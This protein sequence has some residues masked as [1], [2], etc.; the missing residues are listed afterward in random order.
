MRRSREIYKTGIIHGAFFILLATLIVSGALRAHA[1]QLDEI[2]LTLKWKHQFQFAGYYAAQIKGFYR[3][4][5]L[6]V[7][8]EEARPGALPIDSV[9]GGRSQFGVAGPELLN[10]RVHG[11]PVVALAPIFQHSPTIIISRK[12]SHITTP[13]DLIGRTLMLSTSNP[14]AEVRSILFALAI[15]LNKIKVVPHSWNLEAL[16]NGDVDAMTAYSTDAP[17]ILRRRNMTPEIIRPQDY[18]VDFYGD[19]L[20][21]S[22]DFATRAPEEVEAFRRASIQG[23]DYALKHQDEIIR[24]I[25]TL[26][27]VVERGFD[28]A[29]LRFEAN[30][31]RQLIDPIKVGIGHQNPL[32]WRAMANQYVD[33]G[34][35][36][37]NY[38]LDGFFFKG[39]STVS[40]TYLFWAVGILGGLGVLLILSYVWAFQLRRAVSE[41]TASLAQ[42]EERFRAIFDGASSAIVTTDLGGRLTRWNDA[43]RTMLNDDGEFSQQ[44]HQDLVHPDDLE[45]VQNIFDAI[46]SGQVPTQRT[47]IRY[48]RK[49]GG[50]CW[51]EVRL[52]ALRAEN[53]AIIGS[54]AAINDITQRKQSEERIRVMGGALFNSPNMVIVTDTA[55]S[56]EY[57]NPMFTTL[58]GYDAKEVIGKNPRFLQSGETSSEVYAAMWRTIKAG[59]IWQGELKDRRK[60]G[61]Y[62]WSSVSFFPIAGN[63]GQISHFVAMHQDISARKRAQKRVVEAREQAEIANRA[64]SELL[65]N[66]SHE[67][68]TPLNAIIGFSQMIREQVFGEIGHPKYLEYVADIQTSG[69]HLLDLI[70]DILDVSAIEAGRLT[71]Q[72]HPCDMEKII[73][74]ASRLVRPRAQSGGIEMR[75]HVV[76]D[77]PLVRGDERRIKQ[78][79]LNLLS[80]AVKFTE[81]GG[82]VSV[83]CSVNTDGEMVVSICDTGIGMDAHGLAIAKSEF[84]QV[85]SGLNRKNDGAGLGL[86]LTISLVELHGGVFS[87]D[88]T[89]GVGTTARFT[90]PRERIIAQPH[91]P[92]APQGGEDAR[93]PDTSVGAP[94]TPTAPMAVNGAAGE[95]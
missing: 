62:F 25:L 36:P 4:A 9:L 43:F 58:T 70:T 83:S 30:A 13:S 77:I 79:L 93:R 19:T 74:A 28:A 29:Q 18:G 6:D 41:K 39:V 20:F 57:V 55:G 72:E 17:Y 61:S 47:E 73:S 81:R 46:V 94:S 7:K 26:P 16:I 27:G 52:S 75:T 89:L 68:R 53:N 2:R 50:P 66:M 59:R 45:S 1:Q 88:S 8:I 51:G 23:W 34:L 64:K 65:A 76:A 95:S 44:R 35:L 3:K 56:I 11:E 90:L 80:N 48:L 54:I 60:D 5:G 87:I 40:K 22:E 71:L 85:D 33:I 67:L 78:I 31:T 21:T 82:V 32:R 84:G 69:H 63:D 91:A 49:G 24:Y 42:S 10:A 37:S 92:D 38:S 15:P 12:K 86:P 14:E